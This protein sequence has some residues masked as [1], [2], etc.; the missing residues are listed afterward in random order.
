MVQDLDL[1]EGAG[2]DQVAGHLD[3]RFARLGVATGVGMLCDAPGYVQTAIGERGG[4]GRPQYDPG[5]DTASHNRS[6][7]AA[8]LRFASAVVLEPEGSVCP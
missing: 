1:H 4:G 3:V 6:A 7:L 5:S 2:A 8:A